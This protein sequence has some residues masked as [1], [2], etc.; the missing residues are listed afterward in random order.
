MNAVGSS[1][2][3]A[4]CP[5]GGSRRRHDLAESDAADRNPSELAVRSAHEVG[6]RA[7]V[8]ELEHAD[9]L[10][11]VAIRQLELKRDALAEVLGRHAVRSAARLGI[12]GLL[13]H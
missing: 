10:A 4:S 1:V 13:I 3:S 2:T 6:R 8:V 11:D 12:A 7:L 5:G 9:H